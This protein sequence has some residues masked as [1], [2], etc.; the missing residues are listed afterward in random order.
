MRTMRYPAQLLLAGAIAAFLQSSALAQA[1]KELKTKPGV[2]IALVNL[3][4]PRP[5]CTA[6]PGPVVLPSLKQKPAS[7][8]LG[9]QIIVTD[10]AAAGTCPA[11]KIPAIA[12]T[13][14]PNKDFVGADA[15]QVELE[16]GNRMTSLSYRINV[17]PQA[18]PL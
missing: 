10:V 7:G 3:V 4:N 9:M 1:P 18:E 16:I 8:V 15:V 6:N 11:R 13:Y 2:P 17:T 12:L 5:D 14:T